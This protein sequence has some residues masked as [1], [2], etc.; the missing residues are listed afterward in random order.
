MR[1]GQAFHPVAQ[2]KRDFTGYLDSG[3][4]LVHGKFPLGMHSIVVIG[5]DDDEEQ[6]GYINPYWEGTKDVA[7]KGA[8]AV[9]SGWGWLKKKAGF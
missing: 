5:T 6:V 2:V 9:S 4:L 3:P 7:S 8:E 1:Q